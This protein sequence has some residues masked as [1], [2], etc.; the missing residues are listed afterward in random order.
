[1]LAFYADI[2]GRQPHRTVEQ[3][4]RPR[5]D[6]VAGIDGVKIRGGWI[7]VGNMDIE[8]WQYVAPQTAAP[9]GLRKIDEIGYS[10]VGYEVV[11][12]QTQRVR[13]K[14]A[15]VRL[16]GKP[17]R[18]GGWLTQ[19]AHDPEGNIFALVERSGAPAN[20]SVTALR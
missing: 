6:D 12:I 18:V 4:N 3:E 17:R 15:G 1:M 10:S 13:L 19:Y 16:V 11:D 8:A 7:N 5:L 14:R 2:V 20:E 9:V